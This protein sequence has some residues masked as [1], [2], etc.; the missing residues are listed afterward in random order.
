MPSYSER[1]RALA[2]ETDDLRREFESDCDSLDAIF[3]T[4]FKDYLR[5]VLA[6]EMEHL[7]GEIQTVSL[8]QENVVAPSR[9]YVYAF[10]YYDYAFQHY[11]GSLRFGIDVLKEKEGTIWIEG[12]R[13]QIGARALRVEEFL[14]RFRELVSS[15]R[16][17]ELEPEGLSA[18]KM[19]Y[20]ILK[21]LKQL[22]DERLIIS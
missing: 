7:A 11:Y 21:T 19:A 20:G 22:D 15:I 5:R 18:K 2:A 16:S 10:Q 6:E 1:A 17:G 14:Q 12:W 9:I 8:R 13:N 4:R 3:E